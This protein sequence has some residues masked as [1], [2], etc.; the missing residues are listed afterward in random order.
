M[1][2][3]QKTDLDMH[4]VVTKHDAIIAARYY[5]EHQELCPDLAWEAP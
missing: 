3:G 5:Y 2:G 4:F 1:C